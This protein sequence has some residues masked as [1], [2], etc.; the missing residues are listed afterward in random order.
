MTLGVPSPPI[1]LVDELPSRGVASVASPGPL[2]VLHILPDLS[3]GSDVVTLSALL[4]GIPHDALIASL[5]SRDT[6]RL[7]STEKATVI[8]LDCH[9]SHSITSLV[10]LGS[11]ARVFSPHVIHAWGY[12]PALVSLALKL[13][14]RDVPLVWSLDSSPSADGEGRLVTS[15]VRRCSFVASRILY[16]SSSARHDHERGGFSSGGGEV[17]PPP[18]DLTRFKADPE[19][20]GEERARRDWEGLFVVAMVGNFTSSKDLLTFC[21]AA[22]IFVGKSSNV[23]IVF[24]GPGMSS[25]NQSLMSLVHHCGLERFVELLGEVDDLGALLNGIDLLT[26]AGTEGAPFPR[27][28]VEGMACGVPCVVNDVG[29]AKRIIGKDGTVV[30]ARDPLSLFEAWYELYARPEAERREL[31]HRPVTRVRRTFGLKAVSRTYQALYRDL[32]G[33]EV[34]RSQK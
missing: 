32:T 5:T 7:S 33:I 10:T 12:R 18:V 24:A 30:R 22:S 2:R 29:E 1:S 3:L 25:H 27:I 17:V 20:R 31:G 16:A 19:K 15:M 23:K 34:L 11:R 14:L 8:P 21:R 6:P 9:G 26:V 13:N 4:K 28:L